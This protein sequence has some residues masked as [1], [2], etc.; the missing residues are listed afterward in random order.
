[1]ALADQIVDARIDVRSDN[2]SRAS[3]STLAVAAYHTTY[4]D[5]VRAYTGADAIATDFPLAAHPARLAL[6]AAFA[7]NP[8]P[9]TVKLLRLTRPPTRRLTIQPQNITQGYVYAFSVEVYGGASVVT[10]PISYTVPGSATTTTVAAALATAI[11]AA[12]GIAAT[13]STGTITVTADAAGTEFVIVRPT[14]LAVEDL[15]I[16][17]TTVDPGISTDLGELRALDSSWYGLAT[18]YAGKAETLAAAAWAET[19]GSDGS[20]L[21]APQ[22]SD[23]DVSAAV[24]GNL[25]V[26][27]N[28][29]A[30]RRV[31]RPFYV[32][33]TTASHAGTR[34]LA[35]ALPFEPGE[36]SWAYKALSG[37]LPDVHGAT[38]LGNMETL[39]CPVYVEIVAGTPR[40]YGKWTCKTCY[41]EWADVVL[42]LDWLRTEIRSDILVQIANSTKVPYTQGG[43]DQLESTL[44]GTLDRGTAYVIAKGF[45]TTAPKVAAVSMSDK[46]ARKLTGL[47]FQATLQGAITSAVVRGTVTV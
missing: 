24:A 40:V 11:D 9:A 7:Q 29:L 44:K 42:G 46:S 21:Y 22:T 25:A 38:V 36:I 37:L 10:T 41:G 4:V 2:L 5:R 35:M 31:L 28:G 23:Y 1:M 47:K 27:L 45:T 19:N 43:I 6:E 30:Y 16:Q 33:N 14:R 17:D 15:R 34:L 32:A 12:A 3:Y 20:I 26:T 13:A 8:C 39:Q 18:P